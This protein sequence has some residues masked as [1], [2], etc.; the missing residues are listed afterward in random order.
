MTEFSEKAIQIS[1]EA[2]EV[3]F[4]LRILSNQ[5]DT[6]SGRNENRGGWF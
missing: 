1:E 2:D 5:R 6:S 3:V 4:T